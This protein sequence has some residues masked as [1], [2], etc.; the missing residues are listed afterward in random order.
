VLARGLIVLECFSEDRL[1]LQLRELAAMTG[2]DKATLLRLLATFIE[3][4]YVRKCEDGRYS[5]GPSL[6]RLGALYRATFD[7]GARIQPVLR[8]IMEQ[9][10]ESV[11]FYIRNGDQRVCLYRENVRRDVRY[12]FE[13]GTRIP[14][15][16]GGSAS[17]ILRAY[18]DGSSPRTEEVL[19][20]GYAITRAERSPELTS[21]AIPVFDRDG[22]LLGAISITGLLARQTEEEQVKAAGIAAKE[23]E[24]Q[25]FLAHRNGH[26]FPG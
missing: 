20:K 22:V 15:V 8:R 25:G 3:F 17:H 26:G 13:I 12:V 23:L 21:V 2:L 11:A 9:T 14:L 7:L 4:G 1:R 18:T 5:P 16:E 10:G 24:S 19:A 6:L